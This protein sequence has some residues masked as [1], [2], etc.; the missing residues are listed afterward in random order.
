[1]P[2]AIIDQKAL[3]PLCVDL[4]GTLIKTDLVWES[5]MRLLKNNPLFCFVVPV[6]LL[7]GRAYLKRQI[8]QRVSVDAKSLP[9]NEAFVDFL[10]AE[11]AQGRPLY[12]VTASD[13]RL[14]QAVAD[15]LGIFTEVLGSDGKTKPNVHAA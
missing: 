1:M 2:S 4:D 9:Y 14:A 6:W 10:R 13:S 8:S 3:V 7:R 5:L 11:K 15:H 12:L